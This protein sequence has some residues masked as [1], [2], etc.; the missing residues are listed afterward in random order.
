MFLTTNAGRQVSPEQTMVD[1]LIT[2]SDRI[3]GWR[4]ESDIL[5]TKFRGAAYLRGRHAYKTC[6][7]R[8][9]VYPRIEALFAH[10]SREAAVSGGRVSI[11]IA[12]LDAM[13]GGRHPGGFDDDGHGLVRHRQDDGRASLSVALVERRAGPHVRLLRNAGQPAGEG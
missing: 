5:V 2:L 10:P 7:A 13:L 1:G 12:R 3:Y 9:V 11:G 8:I 4:A 6:N